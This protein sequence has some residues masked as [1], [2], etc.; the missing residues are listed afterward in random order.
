MGFGCA[1]Y[2]RNGRLEEFL[3]FSAA[4]PAIDRAQLFILLSP[5]DL[6]PRCLNFGWRCLDPAGL[7]TA[8]L[9]FFVLRPIFRFGSESWRVSSVVAGIM[10]NG[11]GT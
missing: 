7:D 4:E 3:K 10:R 1:L 8:L 2:V 11:A 9:A 5:V 6:L